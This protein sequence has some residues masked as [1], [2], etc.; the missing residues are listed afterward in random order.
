MAWVAVG[1]AAV[2]AV[3]SAYSANK[4]AGASKS[5][6]KANMA[7]Q[8]RQFDMIQANGRPYMDAG[9]GSLANIA[10]ADSGDYSGFMNNPAYL[11][12]RQQALSAS[13]AGAAS[14]GA[15]FS[16]GH[17]AELERL[18]SGYA[19]Q[20]YNDW[21]N[22]QMGLASLGQASAAG[23]GAAGQNMANQNSA[24]RNNAA[25]ARGTAYGAMGQGIA[26]IAGAFGSAYGTHPSGTGGG[27]STP[28]SSGNFGI[29]APSSGSGYWGNGFTWGH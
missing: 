26:G 23:V 6:S 25:D 1:A 28:N 21:R 18:A 2:G 4:A 16:G 19:A 11:F 9:S 7:E 5:A 14:H 24:S 8:Q 15:L 13:D 12:S 10:K 20:N 27:Y 3:G 22:G 29:P 17:A